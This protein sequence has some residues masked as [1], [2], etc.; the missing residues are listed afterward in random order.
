MTTEDN[1]TKV[2]PTSSH[3]GNYLVKT[4]EGAMTAV[5]SYPAD[6]EPSGIAQ[7]L[8]DSQNPDVRIAQ[9]MVRKSYLEHGRKSDGGQR[10][11]EPFVPVSWDVALD[12]AADALTGVRQE[13]GNQAIYG[14][15]YG[16][17]SA[18]RFHHAQSQIHR[19]LRTIGGYVDSRDDYSCA[20]AH[21]I[22][23]RVLG[24]SFYEWGFEPQTIDDIAQ[25]SGSLV[26]FGGAA[27]KNTQINV[28]GLG[29][30]TGRQKLAR[31]KEAGVS[32]YNI[33]PVR[34]DVCE[35]AGARWIACKPNTDTALMLGLIHTLVSEGLHD[36]SFLDTYCEGWDKFHDY[37]MGTTD[38]QAKNAKWASG[39]CG[40][41]DTEIQQLARV[42]AAKRCTIGVSWSLQRQEHG[43]Q[44]YWM[45]ITL[46]SALG[47]MGL[48]GGGITFGYGCVHNI[49][50]SD[51]AWINFSLGAVPQG[52][53]PIDAFI[54]VARISD[55]LLNPGTSY[56][57][58]GQ[59]L[60]YPDIRL[61]YW[62]GGNP[63]HHHQDLNRLRKAWA[64]PETII[65]NE[66]VWT[67]TARHADIV[68]P[69]TTSLER[70]DLGGGSWDTYLTP[71]HKVVE[72]YAQSRDDYAICSGLA[73][74]LGFEEEFTEGL[75]EM[76]WV[77][78]LYE[79]TRINAAQA[80]VQ[81]PDFDAF[82]AG[83]QINIQ[84][85]LP[86]KVWYVEKFRADPVGHPLTTPSGKIEIF[87]STLHS[88]NYADCPGH[89]TWL[90]KD[91][92]LGSELAKT[93]PL[94]LLSNQP[95]KKLHSQLDFGRNSL[96][97]KAQGREI[98]RLHPDDAATRNIR[99][100]D[101]VR[102]FNSRGSC[103]ASAELTD[104]VIPQVVEL[105]TGS[106]YDPEDPQVDGS[107]EVHGNPNVLTRDKGSSSL[108]Q[109]PSAH[110]CLVDVALYQKPLPPIKVF[111]QPEIEPLKSSPHK[112]SE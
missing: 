92:W 27:L 76:D 91:E 39:I 71:M 80:D 59:S 25:N 38:G 87:S 44:S 100:G 9:P 82:W 18:G 29:S 89:A 70:N 60:T 48:P 41:A 55:M 111:S 105:P 2:Y 54:P 94:H 51:R 40:I 26:L 62:A 16:W 96:D 86:E 68:F 95:K 57:Y 46:A 79:E 73:E 23:P 19:F 45:A 32:V 61:I 66:S 35:E 109:G 53:N 97:A 104:C 5:D 24:R 77:K 52:D 75:D 21:N 42:M 65:V 49:G 103:L 34:D 4:V 74:R 99:D 17:A 72:P 6:E 47:Y 88:V 83:E 37:L 30:H 56:D 67:A 31:L 11:K 36:Q 33:S 108:G 81:L 13:F 107:L 101:I 110:S 43:E 28:G 8:L 20:A 50:F 112:A 102:V 78:R 15:S 22:V 93:Y 64:N 14:G 106:W 12:L 90:D 3:W 69:A 58:N 84:D 63:F 7:S 1:A 98:I 10:G 85:Q